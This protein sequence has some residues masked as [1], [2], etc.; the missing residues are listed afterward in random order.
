MYAKDCSSDCGD[1]LTLLDKF[2]NSLEGQAAS[3]LY[4][5]MTEEGDTANCKSWGRIA[6]LKTNI[7][8]QM[9]GGDLSDRLSLTKAARATIDSSVLNHGN[10]RPVSEDGYA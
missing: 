7:D 1:Q 5:T 6:L 3:R 4:S 2:F 8:M 9:K 10:S